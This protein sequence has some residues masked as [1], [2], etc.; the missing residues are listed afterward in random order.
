MAKH[1]TAPTAQA[2]PNVPGNPEHPKPLIPSQA[3]PL[4]GFEAHRPKRL[5]PPHSNE[6]PARP[7]MHPA[8]EVLA[9]MGVTDA[10][11]L[12]EELLTIAALAL[13][14]VWLTPV[15]DGEVGQARLA[16]E[17]VRGDTVLKV[18][19]FDVPRRQSTSILGDAFQPGDAIRVRL[20]KDYDAPLEVTI[21]KRTL[22]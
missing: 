1:P 2:A 7:P 19:P 9:E 17:H 5:V 22:S 21:T 20:L 16:I 4:G 18:W 12:D 3:V 8:G 14:E 6:M 10:R 15:P 13:G 11:P